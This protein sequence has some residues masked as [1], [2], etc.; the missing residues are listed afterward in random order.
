[1]KYFVT[2]ATG[3]IGGRLTEQLINEGHEVVAL[4][5]PRRRRSIWQQWGFT[6]A[7]GDIT[8]KDTMRDPMRGVDGVFHMA[9]WYKVGVESELA[10]KINV[11]GTRNVL[12]LMRELDIPKG[13]YTSTVG[14]FS[15]TDGVLADE[16]YYFDPTREDFLSEYERTKWQAHYEVAQPDDRRRSA[17]DDCHAGAGLRARAIPAAQARHS[18][19]IFRAICR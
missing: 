5:V 13:V 3:F 2:G 9:A 1:M 15:D 10:E 6:L 8:E 14:V 12:E 7:E 19:S 16:S 4:C 11:D 17:V 18:G